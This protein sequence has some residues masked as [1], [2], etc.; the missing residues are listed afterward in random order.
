M[1]I[2]GLFNVYNSLAAIAAGLAEKIPIEMILE[3]LAGVE[4]IHGRLERV[5]SN[6]GFTVFVD[7]AHTPDGLEKCIAAVREFCEGRVITLFGCGGDRDQTKRP[8][9]GECAARLSDYCVVTSDNPRQEAPLD[10]ISDILAGIPVEKRA[11]FCQVEPD[12]KTAIQKAIQMA[13]PG[14][15]VLI[16]GKGHEKKQ[17]MGGEALDFDD[18]LVAKEVLASLPRN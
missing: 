18:C 1:K 16:C 8:L 5:D 10:I 7:Y 4:V 11:D 15:V 12:R 9:M 3:T 13:L 6:H 2:H 14:D 17:I